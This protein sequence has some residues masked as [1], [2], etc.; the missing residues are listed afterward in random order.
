VYALKPEDGAEIW[1]YQLSGEPVGFAIGKD[2]VY[3]ISYEG[4][5]YALK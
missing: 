2:V 1:K 4:K 3:A 5:I